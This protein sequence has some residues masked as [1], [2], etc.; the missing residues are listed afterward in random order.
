MAD[1][2]AE[3]ERHRAGAQREVDELT[4]QKESISTHLAQISQLLGTQMPGLADALKPRQAVGTGQKAV[5]PAPSGP[6]TQAAPAAP[7]R[8][9]GSSQ[10]APATQVNQAATAAPAAGQAAPRQQTQAAPAQQATQ[11]GQ[12]PAAKQPV[13]AKAK[14][15]NND[16]EWWTE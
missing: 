4:K 8:N 10:A 14:A 12:P 2:K 3:I 15:S 6:P 13:S 5:G 11:A 16:E 7:P 1:T 9:G